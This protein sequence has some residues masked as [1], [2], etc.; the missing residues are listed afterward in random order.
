MENSKMSVWFIWS[1]VISAFKIVKGPC[2]LSSIYVWMDGSESSALG[3]AVWVMWSLPNHTQL[4]EWRRWEDPPW[5]ESWQL[6]MTR[7]NFGADN[8]YILKIQTVLRIASPL[9]ILNCQLLNTFANCMTR[10]N[11]EL[12]SYKMYCHVNKVADTLPYNLTI[13]VI[14]PIHDTVIV[15][16]W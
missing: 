8:I 3:E 2:T 12:P 13:T 4:Q 7:L 16:L 5:W 11:I 15:L 9:C 1:H 6:G 14:T 10:L